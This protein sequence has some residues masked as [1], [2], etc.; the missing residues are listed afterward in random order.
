MLLKQGGKIILLHGW[1]YQVDKWDGF[2][3]E[4]EKNGIRGEL[5]QIPG[6]T[7]QLN[8][9]WGINDYV[10]WLKETAGFKKKLILLGH[11]FG[12]HLAI[13]FALTYP[14][15]V[16]KLILIASSGLRDKNFLHKVKR[17]VFLV[18]VKS[19]K[20]FTK[21]RT[22]RKLIYFLAGE[23]DYFQAQENM[24]QTMSLILK[25][26]LT[27]ELSNLKAPTLIIWGSDDKITPITMGKK[28]HAKINGS[29]LKI[30]TGAKHAPFSTHTEE[31]IEK[32]KDFIK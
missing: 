20:L 11:S 5:L 28:M 2:L 9:V 3:H 23:K 13:R 22:A 31:V 7:A 24:K 32:I 8:Q 10:D 14:W 19:G 26:D 15:L 6:L 30:I 12:G 16:E 1:S 17:A 18:L 25:D 27:R 4:L 29:Q 21:S